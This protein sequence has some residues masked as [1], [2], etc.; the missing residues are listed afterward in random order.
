MCSCQ[1]ELM[2]FGLLFVIWS[3]VM[4]SCV[5]LL[6]GEVIC[7]LMLFVSWS[8]VVYSYVLLLI[9]EVICRL[10]LCVLWFQFVTTNNLK[11]IC[12]AHQL[13]H[14]GRSS[15]ETKKD[16]PFPMKIPPFQ[17]KNP[18]LP[19]KILPFP[20]KIPP[21]LMHVIFCAGNSQPVS[22]HSFYVFE[23]KLKNM[24]PWC[25]QWTL[26]KKI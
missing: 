16:F 17:K 23:F 26:K 8:A 6:L 20:M 21:L 2:F 4:Y 5:L 22:Q 3:A 13:V 10:M 14:E 15:L 12:R 11:L 7:S 25:W 1:V 24:F 19:M 9:G 18:P